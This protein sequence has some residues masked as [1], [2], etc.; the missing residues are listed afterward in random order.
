MDTLP[1]EIISHTISWLPGYLSYAIYMHTNMLQY[2]MNHDNECALFGVLFCKHDKNILKRDWKLCM[3]HASIA[4][5]FTWTTNNVDNLIDYYS[6]M[7]YDRLAMNEISTNN[8]LPDSMS[9]EQIIKMAQYKNDLLTEKHINILME[10]KEHIFRYLSLLDS[11]CYEEDEVGSNAVIFMSDTI[12]RSLMEIKFPDEW[13]HS[14]T[15]EVKYKWLGLRFKEDNTLNRYRLAMILYSNV[16]TASELHE[17]CSYDPFYAYRYLMH[18]YYKNTDEDNKILLG[19]IRKVPEYLYNYIDIYGTELIPDVTVDS[20]LKSYPRLLLSRYFIDIDI[21]KF[22]DI[23]NGD[24]DLA[25]AVI[26]RSNYVKYRDI[27]CENIINNNVFMLLSLVVM[28]QVHVVFVEKILKKL[29]IPEYME[30]LERMK[31]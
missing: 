12:I 29:D 2:H 10:N 20:L 26:S 21:N 28:E 23:I 6:I 22:I 4:S 5:D 15:H 19:H 3:R 31:K 8:S 27:V 7:T 25:Y 1:N 9:A 30:I 13:V 14:F 11:V 16:L 24:E 18:N 17:L